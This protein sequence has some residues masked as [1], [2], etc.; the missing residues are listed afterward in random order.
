[1]I[2]SLKNVDISSIQ[3]LLDRSLRVNG[4]LKFEI[5]SSEIKS[6]IS[7]E[8]DNFWKEWKIPSNELYEAQ[9]DFT[10]IKVLF[11][12]GMFFRRT[13]LGYYANQKVDI[14]IHTNDANEA[15]EFEITGK[16]TFGTN[17][18][19]RLKATN[20]RLA[21]SSID[22]NLQTKLFNT[23]TPHKVTSFDIEPNVWKEIGKLVG[24]SSMSD[25]PVAHI[26]FVG[27]DGKIEVKDTAFNFKMS[28]YNGE[29]FTAK[30]PKKSLSFLDDEPMSISLITDPQQGFDWFVIES[31]HASV[32]SVCAAM[33]MKSIGGSELI[34]ETIDT[35]GDLFGSDD[36]GWGM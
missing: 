14:N 34:D 20:Y 10:P 26:E 16:T 24:L 19:T 4:A 33:L 6:S 27:G 21:K 8:D 35:A 29:P 15:T 18:T 5:S 30:F 13:Y 36:M 32:D 22:E 3:V 7:N 25:N 28:D 1:M 31:K 12:N 2:V 11:T 17:L 9:A 23:D